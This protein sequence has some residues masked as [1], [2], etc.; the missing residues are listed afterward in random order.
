MNTNTVLN[1]PNISNN[2]TPQD[3]NIN[4]NSNDLKSKQQVKQLTTK[5]CQSLNSIKSK[6][7]RVNSNF[8]I[9]NFKTKI[10]KLQPTIPTPLTPVSDLYDFA[11]PSNKIGDGFSLY[12]RKKER[13]HGHVDMGWVHRNPTKAHREHNEHGITETYTGGYSGNPKFNVC[14]KVDFNSVTWVG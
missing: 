12:S 8:K 11:V 6:I 3:N 7:T 9:L 1:I 4:N 5:H 13:K 10:P 2:T 14:K